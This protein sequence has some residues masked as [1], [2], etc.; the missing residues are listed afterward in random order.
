VTSSIEKMTSVGVKRRKRAYERGQT[1][2]WGGLISPS[3]Y[4]KENHS[5][6]L[7]AFSTAGREEKGL[8][9]FREEATVNNLKFGMIGLTTDGGPQSWGGQMEEEDR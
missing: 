1:G 3:Y 5:R 9:A 2:C 7:S 4:K 8:G 6:N